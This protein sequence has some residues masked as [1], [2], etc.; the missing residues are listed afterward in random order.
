MVIRLYATQQSKCISSPICGN[1]QIIKSKIKSLRRATEWPFDMEGIKKIRLWKIL[2]MHSESRYA[3]RHPEKKSHRMQILVNN[4][5]RLRGQHHTVKSASAVNK[6]LNNQK[7]A[8][9]MDWP[10]NE[11]KTIAIAQGGAAP[12]VSFFCCWYVQPAF[13]KHS[14]ICG[15]SCQD[16]IFIPF[17]PSRTKKVSRPVGIPRG[18]WSPIKSG[19]GDT[20]IT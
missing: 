1:A 9:V 3:P 20:Y 7:D 12:S 17:S 19:W 11:A 5:E 16:L 8:A 14:L 2:V 4:Y 15:V 10:T 18:S 13:L 6:E